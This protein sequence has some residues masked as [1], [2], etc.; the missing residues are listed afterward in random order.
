VLVDGEVVGVVTSGNLSP[1]LG[2]GIAFAFVP[3]A[4][5]EGAAVEV[6]IR[7]TRTPATV[8]ATP[9]YRPAG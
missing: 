7:G 9:F 3:P 5:E 6:D 8:V 4:L 1:T 2:R